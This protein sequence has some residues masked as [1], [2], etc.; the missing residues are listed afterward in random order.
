MCIEKFPSPPSPT[1]YLWKY[2]HMSSIFRISPDD[3]AI[4]DAHQ[5][6]ARS[7]IIGLPSI[8]L[9]SLSR[10]LTISM[11]SLRLYGTKLTSFGCVFGLSC[12][13]GNSRSVKS[14]AFAMP[15]R[16]NFELCKYGHSKIL[17]KSMG[18][19]TVASI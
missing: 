9:T 6:S 16:I 13:R 12:K 8:D 19:L 7:S 4:F 18:F 15:I 10:S 3:D 11:I 1:V 14:N 2:L 17:Y 5:T